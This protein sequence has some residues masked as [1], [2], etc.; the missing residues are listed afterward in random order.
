[1]ESGRK[2]LARL[3]VSGYVLRT[4]TSF[5]DWNV[6]SYHAHAHAIVDSPSGGRGFIPNAAFEDEW[7]SALPA[8][9]HPV[10]NGVHV[11]PVR[12]IE[13]AATYL[14]KSPFGSHLEAVQ[15]TVATIAATKGLQRLSL[16]GSLTA[17]CA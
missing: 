8:S 11:S 5:E 9:L 7:L 15:R 16:R 12:D 14:S 6:G 13:A 10:T 4:E 2:A 17:L 1:M 3:G